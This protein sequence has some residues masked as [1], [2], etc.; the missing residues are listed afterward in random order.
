MCL[1][2][3]MFPP[4]LACRNDAELSFPDSCYLK[5]EVFG[6]YEA[7]WSFDQGQPQQ[8]L[9]VMFW[10]CGKK[11]FCHLQKLLCTHCVTYDQLGRRLWTSRVQLSISPSYAMGWPII[12]EISKVQMITKSKTCCLIISY[13]SYFLQPLNY[14]TWKYFKL[15]IWAFVLRKAVNSYTFP[16]NPYNLV[17]RSR[18]GYISEKHLVL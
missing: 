11:L 7:D 17:L 14:N 8:P 18:T 16:I 3:S 1:N 13:L 15:Y 5:C 4:P 2:S 9:N 10:A 6:C 12:Y